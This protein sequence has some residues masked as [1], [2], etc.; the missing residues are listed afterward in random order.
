MSTE[1]T[2][3]VQCWQEIDGQKEE[4]PCPDNVLDTSTFGILA[5]SEKAA[6]R[7][8]ICKACP[9]YKSILFMCSECGCVMPA[10]TKLDNSSCPLGKW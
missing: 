10:K 9:S 1:D 2:L 8:A 6:Q 3:N 4:I 7:M 5:S